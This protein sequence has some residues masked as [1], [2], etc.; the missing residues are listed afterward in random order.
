M[1]NHKLKIGYIMQANAVDMATV[2]GPQLHVKAVY[3]GLKMRGH[4]VRMIAIQ[5]G[6]TVCTDDLS[7]WKPGVYGFSVSKLF[8]LVESLTRGVQSRLSLPFFR[9][10]DSYRFS[11]ACVS[12]FT[13]YD[14][15]YERDS[16]ISYGGLI[17]A[18]R[19]GIPILLEV[20]GDLIEEWEHL[21]L[22][23]SKG[24]EV[25][26]HF[27][28]RQVYLHVSHIVA[29]GRT[30]RQRL[31]DRWGLKPDH[32]S[33]V[34]NGADIE[35]FLN[36]N[37]ASDV[38]SRYLIGNGPV[39]I[40]TGGFQP[41]HGIELILKAFHKF[42]M[43]R[44]DAKLILVGD[45][46]LKV[47]VQDQ[48]LALGLGERVLF[49]GRVDHKQVAELLN[50]SDVAVI[51]HRGS[52][53]E[54]VETPLKLFEYMAAGKAI[55]APA[56]PNM[57]RILTDHVN[58]LLIPPDDPDSLA[59]AFLKLLEDDQ[60]RRCMGQAARKAAIEK[61]SWDRAVSELEDILY[62]QVRMT[63]E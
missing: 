40:F 44:A 58:A 14:V 31:I 3:N 49:T 35:L 52:A 20:N 39:I 17:A 60:L 47:E 6:E 24:Q 32:I 10:F 9:L 8:R 56:V 16:T 11:E 7:T 23:F 15:L 36:T 12:A 63:R 33:V 45:G 48:T 53:A 19:L 25:V 61:H 28:T 26:V 4:I 30:I 50:I 1:D 37:Y 41:W 54:I 51:Y 59:N 46:P 55:V 29:V 38:R 43:S 62:R 57:K 42:T 27:I 2:S 5:K 18:R 21:G 22:H 13:G 34:T